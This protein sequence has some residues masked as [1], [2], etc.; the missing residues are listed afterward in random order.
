MTAMC[1]MTGLIQPTIKNGKIR[2]TK[3]EYV[4]KQML[5]QN[6]LNEVFQRTTD[7][8]NI[9][10]LDAISGYISDRNFRVE[11]ARSKSYAAANAVDFVISAY[12]L[13]RFCHGV[14]DRNYR[15]M[16]EMFCE[17]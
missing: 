16:H 15:V 8:I 7:N 10:N 3:Y 1:L 13:A 12:N 6:F 14:R 9:E 5:N 17:K 11:A 4:K 2:K